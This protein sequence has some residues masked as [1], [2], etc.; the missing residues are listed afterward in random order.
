MRSVHFSFNKSAKQSGLTLAQIVHCF[1]PDHNAQ[2]HLWWQWLEKWIKPDWELN[3][4]QMQVNV[5][6]VWERNSKRI[7]KW[8]IGKRGMKRANET[9]K[10]EWKTR[11]KETPIFI[12]SS[13]VNF[14]C[15]FHSAFAFRKTKQ[16][17]ILIATTWLSVI[18]YR[19]YRRT[20]THTQTLID[21][22]GKHSQPI[23]VQLVSTHNLIAHISNGTIFNCV[24]RQLSYH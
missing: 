4:K 23:V 19:S 22:T 1:Q 2:T 12:Y 16:I 10:F 11:T 5:N 24:G 8:S 7:L 14:I 9:S 6:R 18:D 13:N 17:L 3:A 15:L 20:Q 21:C